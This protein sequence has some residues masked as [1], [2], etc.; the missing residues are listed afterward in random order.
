[1][2]TS[3]NLYVVEEATA[4]LDNDVDHWLEA[5][6]TDQHAIIGYAMTLRNLIISR[7]ESA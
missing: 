6:H 5:S 1:M 2:H 7:Q 4:I 3:S